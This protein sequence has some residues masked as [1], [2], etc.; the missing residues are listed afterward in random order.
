MS[1]V[2]DAPSQAVAFEPLRCGQLVRGQIGDQSHGFV[3]A[4]D[5]LPSQQGY[6]GSKGESDVLRSRGA[7]FQGATF[8][9]A[10]ILFERAGPGGSRGQ[11]GKNPS[12]GRGRFSQC[13]G[14]G[15]ADCFLRSADSA[16]RAP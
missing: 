6:L 7:T 11:R 12:V 2:F 3:F 1:S 14:A 13:F 4:S 8:R 5:M 10:F 15:W 16:L 9:N